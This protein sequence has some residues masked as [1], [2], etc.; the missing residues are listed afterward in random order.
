MVEME[1]RELLDFYEFPGDDTPIVQG[2]ALCALDDSNEKL[3]KE[4]ILELMAEVDTFIPTPTRA[5]DEPFLMPIEDVFSI[6]G[7][8]TVVTGRVEQGVI[9][10]GDTVEMVGIKETTST[11]CTGVEM[12]H[13]NL[14][15]GE[16]GDNLGALLRGTKRD[17]V[18]RGQVLCAPGSLAP[19]TEFG[20]EVY[21]LTKQE[22][23]RHKPFFTGYRPQFF[24]RTADITGAVTLEEGTDMVM[25]GD[26]TNINIELITP[27]AMEAGLRF[28]IREGGNTV[29]A[30]VVTSVV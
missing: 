6:A 25:P 30:G 16:A 22:G 20:A 5:L 7:R 14:T 8:G 2:S 13:K 23:G 12:F 1:V 3:G 24:F 15:R 19:S 9:N 11:T 21:V 28:A 29:G 17:E 4:A 27:V 10:A 18:L 26:N